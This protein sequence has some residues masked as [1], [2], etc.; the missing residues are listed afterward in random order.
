M[1]HLLSKIQ[2]F[3]IKS[4]LAQAASLALSRNLKILRNMMTSPCLPASIT[5]R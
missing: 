5:L 3:K 4:K 1:P 2:M